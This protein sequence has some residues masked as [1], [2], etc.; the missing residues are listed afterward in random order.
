MPQTVAA[1]PTIPDYHYPY[2][3]AS[4]A[5]GPLAVPAATFLGRHDIEDKKI[6]RKHGELLVISYDLG[7]TA[8][9]HLFIHR[10]IR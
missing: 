2:V 8:C 9:K 4:P 1:A 6:A 7:T 3:L 5:L 10:G